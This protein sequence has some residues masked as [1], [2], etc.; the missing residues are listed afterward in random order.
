MDEVKWVKREVKQHSTNNLTFQTVNEKWEFWKELHTHIHTLKNWKL[1]SAFSLVYDL[2]HL[3][4][5]G[6]NSEQKAEEKIHGI[7]VILIGFNKK[8]T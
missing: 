2:I 3:S 8:R 6:K 1:Q 5:A 4:D 7:L